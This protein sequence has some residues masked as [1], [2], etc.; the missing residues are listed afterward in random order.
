MYGRERI[1]KPDWKKIFE[2]EDVKAQVRAIV[3]GQIK[4][5]E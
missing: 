1:F 4:P 3:E 5:K 2:P